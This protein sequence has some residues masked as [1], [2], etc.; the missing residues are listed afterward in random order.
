[1]KIVSSSSSAGEKICDD[2]RLAL[3]LEKR[4]LRPE[5][6]VLLLLV[7]SNVGASK[8]DEERAVCDFEGT[9]GGLRAGIGRDGSIDLALWWNERLLR[10]ALSPTSSAG[11]DA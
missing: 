9:G 11:M 3:P 10:G 8:L 1:M 4:R 5:G 2:G 6:A 7:C